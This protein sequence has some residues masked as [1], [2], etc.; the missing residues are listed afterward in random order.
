MD[1]FRIYDDLGEETDSETRYNEGVRRKWVII[2]GLVVAL[3]AVFLISLIINNIDYSPLDVLERFFTHDTS[4]RIGRYVWNLDM[5]ILLA[6]IVAGAGLSLAGVVMQ[7]VLRNP[8]ASPYTLGLSNAAA[9]GA[10]F[11]IIVFDSGAAISGFLGDIIDPL[12]AFVFAMVAVGIVIV[13]AKLTRI[14][15]ETMVLA[16]IAVSAIFSAG[17][18]LM[19]YLADPVQLSNIVRWTFGDLSTAS[20]SW[21]LVL[22]GVL[23]LVSLYF[24]YHRWTMNA[25]NAGDEVA[26]GLGVNTNVFLVVGLVLSGFV[27]ALV[28]SQF[29]VIAFVGLLGP[30]M[31]RMVLGDDHRLLIPGSILMGAILLL[32]AQL[33]AANIVLPMILPV[34]L[35][36][37]LL[38][39]PVFIYLMLRRFRR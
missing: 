27:A 24:F 11:G 34:G 6:A 9:F 30:H 1:D 21:D 35:M 14:S 17:L 32:V 19:Q 26:K 18:T 15:S 39:G 23:L 4:D 10:A 29:G 37:S 28:V 12:L 3:F 8:L 38:G 16:G 13:L 2:G 22:L 20:T 31:A 25:L 33:V 5:P 7:C 36:T